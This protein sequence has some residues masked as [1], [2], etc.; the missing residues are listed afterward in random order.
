MAAI[1]SAF[2][3]ITGNMNIEVLDKVVDTLNMFADIHPIISIVVKALM[4]PYQMWRKEGVFMADVK[5]LAS[6]MCS[7]LELMKN[8][9]PVMELE[10]AKNSAAEL[11][12]LVVEASKYVDGF[13]NIG[14]IDGMYRKKIFDRLKRFAA[15][16]FP[17]KLRDYQI[18]LKDCRDIFREAVIIQ[19]LVNINILK[20]TTFYFSVA[21]WNRRNNRRSMDAW[22]GLEKIYCRK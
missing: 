8:A 14:K 16:Q 4:I 10:Y 17:K 3:T 20:A 7:S 21:N 15:A 22:K 5:T 19:N 1:Q 11:L 6:D 18:S 9:Y 13:A 2:P 12:K